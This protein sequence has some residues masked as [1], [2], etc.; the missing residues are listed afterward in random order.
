MNI[1]RVVILLAIFGALYYGYQ[2][3]Q[4]KKLAE[5]IRTELKKP[6]YDKL[7]A[8]VASEMSANIENNYPAI[9]HNIRLKNFRK[10]DYN[11][12]M[13]DKMKTIGFL[14]SCETFYHEFAQEQ[15]EYARK[16]LAKIVKEDQIQISYTVKD[17]LGDVIYEDKRLVSSCTNF[18]TLEAGGMPYIPEPL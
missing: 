3:Y 7:P 5:Q 9:N 1:N 15:N 16:L 17:K 6:I 8:N 12:E 2:K 14:S 11:Q 13:I 10:S 4:D 18:D